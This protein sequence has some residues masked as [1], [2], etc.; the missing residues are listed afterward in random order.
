MRVQQRM[1]KNN[2]NETKVV[3]VLMLLL[4]LLALLSFLAPSSTMLLGESFANSCYSCPSACSTSFF[5]PF[6]CTS[7]PCH[8]PCLCCQCPLHFILLLSTLA[9]AVSKATWLLTRLY[10]PSLTL[11]SRFPGL[12]LDLYA[13]LVPCRFHI[14][15]SRFLMIGQIEFRLN[16]KSATAAAAR[17]TS[18]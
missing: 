18:N 2:N 10:S 17:A 15:F 7:F 12:F 4:L 11:T 5:S 9:R 8:S 3:V 1:K 16:L 14:C 6:C 13:L